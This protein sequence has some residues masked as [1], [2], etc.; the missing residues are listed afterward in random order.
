MRRERRR[1]PI[2]DI[3]GNISHRI[4]NEMGVALCGL[5]L[6]VTEQLTDHQQRS[7]L[8]GS[9][10]GKGM[11]QVMQPHLAKSGPAAKA[12]P[13]LLQID[14]MRSGRSA[15]DDVRIAFDA[16]HGVQHLHRRLIEKDRLGTGLRL[17]QKNQSTLEVDVLPF[18]GEDFTEA[19]SCEDQEPY[20]GDHIDILPF[21]LG[22]GKDGAQP[23]E[24]RLR[25]EPLAVIFLETFDVGAW[26]RVSGT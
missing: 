24:L 16:R 10:T 19:S 14:Q 21:P 20:S 25:Q 15:D 22:I 9:E 13:G 7:A 12:A 11:A 4:G 5:R 2:A 3:F 6:R 8:G 26:V 18:E 23:V 1:K 17:R